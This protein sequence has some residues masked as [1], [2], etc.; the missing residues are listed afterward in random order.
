MWA[1]ARGGL[2]R[3]CPAVM[4]VWTLV[5]LPA[6]AGIAMMVRQDCGKLCSYRF[7]VVLENR[8][9]GSA[10]WTRVGSKNAM[11]VILPENINESL[12]LYYAYLPL[13]SMVFPSLS[14]FPADPTNTSSK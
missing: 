2:G 3:F 11:T 5:C 10:P 4:P 8:T 6:Y 1:F 14:N 9:H 13:I 7:E 12:L